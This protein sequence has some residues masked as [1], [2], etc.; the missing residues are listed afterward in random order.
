MYSQTST[1]L[2]LTGRYKAVHPLFDNIM[3]DAYIKRALGKRHDYVLYA[4]RA[5]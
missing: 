1:L 3:L 4:Y 5:L 2:L